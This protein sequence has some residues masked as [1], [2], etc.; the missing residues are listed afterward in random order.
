MAN[1]HRC[2][3]AS[4][5][6]TVP[7]LRE[8]PTSTDIHTSPNRNPSIVTMKS[9]ASDVLKTVQDALEV[10]EQIDRWGMLSME[11]DAKAT[12]RVVKSGLFDATSQKQ[13]EFRPPGVP[14]PPKGS[15]LNCSHQTSGSS[16]ASGVA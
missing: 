5:S 15:P 14:Y 1:A 7:R 10:L 12:L 3:E 9:L 8:P 6:T 11:D 16:L 13:M 4:L 2:Q